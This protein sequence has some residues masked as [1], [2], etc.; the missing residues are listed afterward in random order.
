VHE[1]ALGYDSIE[2]T[3]NKFEIWIPQ[4]YFLLPMK[5]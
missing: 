1:K 4:K 3:L 5:V 2:K